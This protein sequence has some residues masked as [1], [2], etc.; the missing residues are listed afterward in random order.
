VHT[1][2]LSGAAFI[3]GPL[4]TSTIKTFRINPRLVSHIGS[5]PITIKLTDYLG[6][7]STYILTVNVYDY[8]RFSV[9]V[10]TSMSM[11]INGNISYSLPVI[12]DAPFTTTLIGLKMPAFTNLTGFAFN[13]LPTL[14]SHVGA[15]TIIGDVFNTY[16]STKF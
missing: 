14:A 13:F 7:F 3:T 11:R 15:F 1:I 9:P 2:P 6:V 12:I 5:Y 8:P 4:P 16:L 10:V